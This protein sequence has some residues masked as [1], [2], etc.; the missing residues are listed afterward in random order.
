MRGISLKN[1]TA[2]LIA[3][4]F[5]CTGPVLLIINISEGLSLSTVDT[6]SWIFSIY[7]FGGL[8]GV[9]LSRKYRIPISGAYTISGAALL[10]GIHNVSIEQL[11]GAFLISGVIILIVGITGI[12]E[13]LLNL[14]PQPIIMSM[15]SGV[16]IKFMLSLMDSMMDNSII[17]VI[18][19]TGFF[20][21]P[22]MFNKQQSIVIAIAAGFIASIVFGEIQYGVYSSGFIM[23]RLLMPRISLDLIATISIPLSLLI[24]GSENAQAIAILK[25]QEYKPHI[26]MITVSSGIMSI[27]AS[28]FGGHS[29]NAAGPM[30]AICSSDDAGEDREYRYYASLINGMVYMAFGILSSYALNFVNIM[31]KAFISTVAGL[32]VYGI[33]KKTL[34]ISFSSGLFKSGSAIC[35]IVSLSNIDILKIGAPI[36]AGIIGVIVSVLTEK[37][38]FKSI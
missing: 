16:L 23:P 12:K 34:N 10:L 30:T 13:K 15:I 11:A 7:F 18:T 32:S 36:W 14:V 8:M 25:A 4:I 38:D 31:P 35:F 6:I 29:V 19:L 3:S 33:I 37:D 26:N 27:V 9:I 20:I 1:I 5:G 24:M 22:K 28:F 2:G 17:F 21:I